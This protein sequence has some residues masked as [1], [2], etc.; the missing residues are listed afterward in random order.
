VIYD[1]EALF[2]LRDIEKARVLGTAPPIEEQQRMIAAEMTLAHGADG[3]VTV[4]EA[5]ALH[6][7]QAGHAHVHVLG[8]AIQPCPTVNDFK[9]RRGFLF[10]GAIGADDTPNTD[11]LLWFVRECW[12]SIARA[13]GDQARLDIVGPC[14]SDSVR[15]LASPAIRVHGRVGDLA[16]FFDCARVFIVPTRFAAGIPHKA[17]EAAAHGLPMV[18]SPLIATQLGWADR[19][20]AGATPAQFSEACVQLHQEEAQWSTCRSALLRAVEQ[21]CSPAAF[22]AAATRAVGL[23]AA[24]VERSA[25]GIAA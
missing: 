7:R 22:A 11:S 14:D 9:R 15:A 6:F 17:H 5:E 18:V 24:L 4:S 19:V 25:L 23:T 10:V 12:P 1:A 13:L 21:D 16:P 3:I 8:H 20:P 2:S